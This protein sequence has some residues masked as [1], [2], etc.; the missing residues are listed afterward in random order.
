ML[1]TTKSTISTAA[2]DPAAARKSGASCATRAPMPKHA[3]V[4]PHSDALSPTSPATGAGDP[5]MTHPS[6][7]ANPAATTTAALSAANAAPRVSSSRSRDI[8]VESQ[9]STT[10]RSSSRRTAP[11]ALSRPQAAKT[12]ANTP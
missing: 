10:P 12:I 4:N 9:A 7:P 6:Q 3:S 5:A 1:S 2:P 11:Q 8:L